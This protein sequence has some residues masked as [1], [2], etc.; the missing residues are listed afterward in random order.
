MNIVDDIEA[1]TDELDNITFARKLT[2]IY[3]DSKVIG[4]VSNEAIINFAQTHR[5]F[6]MNP[7]KL[8][9]SKEKFILDT[10]KSKKTFIKLLNDDFLTSQLTNSDYEA[11]AKNNT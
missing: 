1:L 10:K 11:L 6:K 8:T 2:R 5:Y 3:K 7:I 9:E 4:K